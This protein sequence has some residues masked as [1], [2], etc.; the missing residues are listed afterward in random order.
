MFPRFHVYMAPCANKAKDRTRKT[1]PCP[2]RTRQPGSLA[3]CFP[4]YLF[5][6]SHVLSSLQLWSLFPLLRQAARP[7]PWFPVN[8]YPGIQRQPPVLAREPQ[9]DWDPRSQVHLFPCLH[10]FPRGE[11]ARVPAADAAFRDK[12]TRFPVHMYP[13]ATL[14]WCE[15]VCPA[16]CIRASDSGAG[17]VSL[18]RPKSGVL[19]EL[20]Y[21]AAAVQVN[22]VPRKPA[23]RVTI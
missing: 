22:V 7:F 5:P 6:A 9:T 3:T 16:G 18:P 21:L 10:G 15:S 4:A 19:S 12:A 23:N 13:N 2:R 8:R 20:A 1:Q 11:G 17:V 14:N